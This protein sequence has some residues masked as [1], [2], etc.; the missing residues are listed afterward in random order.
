MAVNYS[1]CS[2]L[3]EFCL[4][5][6]ANVNILQKKTQI[7]NYKKMHFATSVKRWENS[8]RQKSVSFEIIKIIIQYTLSLYHFSVLCP[9]Q[10]QQQQKH[11]K[12]IYTN[13]ILR[14]TESVT[15]TKTKRIHE[16]KT[17][18][19]IQWKHE[20]IFIHNVEMIVYCGALSVVERAHFYQIFS[21]HF[22]YY[23][24][25]NGSFFFIVSTMFTLHYQW[26]STR[27]SAFYV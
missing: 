18:P 19:I 1:V 27:F 4:D 24:I 6:W 13:I 12:Y 15:I 23:H 26:Q 3:S 2:I 25:L 10:Q 20:R 7:K 22:E 5:F 8:S 14:V 17:K 11:C 9:K 16:I 21:D